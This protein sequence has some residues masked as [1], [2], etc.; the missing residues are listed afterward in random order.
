MRKLM[1]YVLTLCLL[2]GLLPTAVFA[3]EDTDE[4]AALSEVAE[5][6]AKEAAEDAAEAAEETAEA[7]EDSDEETSETVSGA[8]LFSLN[9][10]PESTD[11]D[12][13][14]W[15]AAMYGDGEASLLSVVGNAFENEYL[16]TYVDDYGYYTMG[17]TG[18]NPDR[19]SDDNKLLLY[20]HPGSST[21]N[22]LIRIDG[23][24]FRFQSDSVRTTRYD[25]HS[26]SVRLFS[27]GTLEVRQILTLVENPQTARKDIVQIRY[28]YKNY[29]QQTREIG[30]RIMLDT[31]LGY[32]DGA[33]FRV[34]EDQVRYEREYV[35]NDIPRY[36]TCFDSFD[37]PTVISTGTLYTSEASRPSKVQFA[38]W[39][40]IVSS[41]WDYQTNSRTYMGDTAVAVYFDPVSVAPGASGMVETYYGLSDTVPLVGVLSM[42]AVKPARMNAGDGDYESNPFDVALYAMNTGNGPLTNVRFNL[43]LEDNTMEVVEGSGKTLE[44]LASGAETSVLW[45]LRALPQEAETTAHYKITADYDGQEAQTVLELSTELAAL[46]MFRTVRFLNGEEEVATFQV[47]NGASFAESDIPAVPEKAR[48]GN[49]RYEGYWDMTNVSLENITADIDIPCAYN[50]IICPESIV[51]DPAEVELHIGSTDTASLT[52]TVLPENAADKSITWTTFNEN[53]ATVSEDGVVTAVAVGTAVIMAICNDDPG[54]SAACAVTVVADLQDI[55]VTPPSPW[56]MMQGAPLDITGLVVNAVYSDGTRTEIHGYTLTGYDPN[57]EGLGFGYE[58]D[59][60]QL[61]DG[62]EFVDETLTI[63][64]EGFEKNATVTIQRADRELT[65]IHI[66]R[67]PNKRLNYQLGEK[68]N[69]DGMIVN[70]VYNDGNV[71]QGPTFANGQIPDGFE[72]T[73]YDPRRVGN[74]AITVSYGGKSMQYS[75]RVLD[76]GPLENNVLQPR[77]S[78]ESGLGYKLVTLSIPE[79]GGDIPSGRIYYTTDGSVPTA[80]SQEYRDPIRLE[81]AATVK[82]IAISGSE[83][84]PITSCNVALPRVSAPIVANLHHRNNQGL[85]RSMTEL[86]PGTLVSLRSDTDGASIFYWIDGKLGSAEESRY[87]TSIYMKPDYADE[88]GN[89][90]VKAY[91]TKDGYQNSTVTTL[92][93]HLNM[94]L[95]PE[96]ATISVGSVNSRAGEMVSPTLSINTTGV[97]YI[98]HFT[99]HIKYDGGVFDFQSANSLV[100]GVQIFSSRQNTGRD[101]EV[102]IQYNG[103]VQLETGEVCALNFRTFDSSEDDSYSISVDQAN[104][105]VETSS[106]RAMLYDFMDGT[107]SLF[108][109]HNSQLTATADIVDANGNAISVDDMEPGAEIQA[110]LSIELPVVVT[111]SGGDATLNAAE[112]TFRVLNIFVAVYDSNGAMA[113]LQAWDVDVTDPTNLQTMRRIHLDRKVPGGK[114]RFMIMS[115]DLAPTTAANVL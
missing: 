51:I 91:A 21:S 105:T 69:L 44:S 107:I 67:A 84:S 3:V 39:P 93:Y 55:E 111:R 47:A 94:D 92:R 72:I 100:D 75:I 26:E 18:G 66:R 56:V 30:V 77:V 63:A 108:G 49:I 15:K 60:G 7:A 87:G 115:E 53:V 73:G 45:T 2:L 106:T 6:A 85:N 97:G 101:G 43:E 22:T 12:Y 19:E 88:S 64:Y 40:G 14:D 13:A 99:I 86:E 54:I 102:T 103:G 95:T 110:R 33:P 96:I 35:G 5:G 37:S 81:Q 41:P 61:V 65:A 24:D 23:Q 109:S 71:E 76:S 80:S 31:M 48:N 32:N 1:A 20:G 59:E 113:S 58:D 46:P 52:A 29:S 34:G 98:T 36:W 104:V 4:T 90:V 74:Q 42:Q 11:A 89:V 38:S 70:L 68:L 17:T 9:D 50:E 114:L 8:Y 28:E 27:G 16:N 82:A 78:I 57:P 10:P 62:N 112:D 83:Q 79:G 25:E